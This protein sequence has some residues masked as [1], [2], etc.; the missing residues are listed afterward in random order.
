MKVL[1]RDCFFFWLIS[2]FILSM[3]VLKKYDTRYSSVPSVLIFYGTT[4]SRKQHL[5]VL[6]QV[7]NRHSAGNVTLV[8]FQQTVIFSYLFIK[9]IAKI[10]RI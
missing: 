10:D 6:S 7:L 5:I 2:S 1:G 8:N 4:V 3:A 9:H